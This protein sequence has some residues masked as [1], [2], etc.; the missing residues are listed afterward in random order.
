[1]ERMC[2]GTPIFCRVVN[3][4]HDRASDGNFNRSCY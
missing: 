4:H 1:L 2:S 3:A